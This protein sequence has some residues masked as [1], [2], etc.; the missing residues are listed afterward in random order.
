MR[1][2]CESELKK[3]EY[4]K[5]MLVYTHIYIYLYIYGR[6]KWFVMYW[7]KT[8]SNGVGVLLST[9]GYTHTHRT[10]ATA[11][12]STFMNYR[13]KLSTGRYVAVKSEEYACIGYKYT[14]MCVCRWFLVIW[15]D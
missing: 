9:C 1:Y 7:E 5:C 6:N 4:T 10:I 2:F 8:V 13:K 12:V 15:V 11:T 3:G 14:W